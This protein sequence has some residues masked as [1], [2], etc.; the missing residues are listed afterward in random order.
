MVLLL[1]CFLFISNTQVAYATDSPAEKID[2]FNEVIMQ[3][4]RVFLNAV[5]FP[6]EILSFA[7]CGIQ[8]LFSGFLSAPKTLDKIKKQIVM[9]C[10]ALLVFL[11]LPS[12]IGW[13]VDIFQETGW[14]PKKYDLF[15]KEV[16]S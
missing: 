2:Q 15:G 6:L 4:Y 14:Q 7:S 9:S 8:L 10:A 5:I 16:A 1:I 11:L 12:I 13:G 3:W